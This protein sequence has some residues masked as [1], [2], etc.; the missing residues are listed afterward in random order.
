MSIS[1]SSGRVGDLVRG[2]DQLVG[3]LAARREHRDDLLAAPRARR[4]SARAARLMSSASATEVPPNFIT[5][6]SA[7]IGHRR[8]RIRC[9]WTMA[10]HSAAAF[11]L[12][13]ATIAGV[14]E[15]SRAPSPLA[16]ARRRAVALAVVAAADRARV[17]SLLRRR[18]RARPSAGASACPSRRRPRRPVDEMTPGRAG[19][20]G[21]AGRLRR[22][23]TPPPAF[24]DELR[25]RQL[26]GVLVGAELGRA[27]TGTALVGALRAAGR[28]GERI[29]PL[30]VAARRAARYRSFADLPPERASSRSAT[31]GRRAR[32]GVGARGGGGAARRRLRPQPGA[33]RRR[34]DARQPD[35]RPRLLRR[36]AHGR[37]S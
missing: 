12:R 25:S 15:D 7:V 20:P 10:A 37:P 14:M 6:V 11:G 21:A 5:T 29:P 28:E 36:P 24:V 2:V 32:R 16:I 3:G 4:R 13:L 30:I 22:A 1:R 35:R 18:R 33:G 9:A 26:G 34:R 19:R 23:P 31:S 17:G 8:L 27:A